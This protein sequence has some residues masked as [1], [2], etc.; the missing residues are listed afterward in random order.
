MRGHVK[1]VEG[2]S[3]LVAPTFGLASCCRHNL[4]LYTG[5]GC[6][7]EPK[8][9]RRSGVPTKR[10]S[11]STARLSHDYSMLTT[12]DARQIAGYSL[13]SAGWQSR[14]TR[15]YS[16]L[17]LAYTRHFRFRHSSYPTNHGGHHHHHQQRQQGAGTQ[18]A[19]T[20][21]KY[22]AHDQAATVSPFRHP[23]LRPLVPTPPCSEPGPKAVLSSPPARFPPLR[24]AC[25]RSPRCLADRHPR[26]VRTAYLCDPRPSGS[27][28][29]WYVS[30]SGGNSLFL[31]GQS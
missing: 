26:I 21:G 17:Y 3:A 10:N 11:K 14:R 30:L 1:R 27:G 29:S 5:I 12:R 19:A 13:P 2:T 7:N 28:I 9:L 24:D 4:S 18:P 15:F 8:S 6:D 25:L 22:G 20:D 16:L 31:C 23:I